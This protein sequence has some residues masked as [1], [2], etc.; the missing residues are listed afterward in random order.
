[1]HCAILGHH[2]TVATPKILMG[3]RLLQRQDGGGGNQTDSHVVKLGNGNV[4][5]PRDKES[6]SRDSTCTLS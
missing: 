1:M 3:R 2:P 6:W 4:R 5:A